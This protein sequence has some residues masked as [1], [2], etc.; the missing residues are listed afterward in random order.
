[1]ASNDLLAGA[2]RAKREF[3]TPGAK[4]GHGGSDSLTESGVDSSVESR[5]PGA[6]VSYG[7]A[8]SGGGDHREIPKSEG[9]DVL[10]SGRTTKAKDFEGQAGPEDKADLDRRDRGG[11]DDVQTGSA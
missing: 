6:Q 11:G 10:K 8:A 9:G 5:F 4:E 1:M 7:S 3:N 2:A